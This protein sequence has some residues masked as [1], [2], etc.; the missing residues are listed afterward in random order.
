MTPTTSSDAK[1]VKTRESIRSMPNESPISSS[2]KCD[3]RRTYESPIGNSAKKPIT[4][5][6]LRRGTTQGRVGICRKLSTDNINQYSNTNKSSLCVSDRIASV[7]STIEAYD[8]PKAYLFYRMFQGVE[9]IETT[10]TDGIFQAFSPYSSMDF[11]KHF[12]SESN[13]TNEQL[14]Y[15]L[16]GYG[17]NEKFQNFQTNSNVQNKVSDCIYSLT[18]CKLFFMGRSVCI[19]QE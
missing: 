18:L 14:D 17:I 13:D 15:H 9:E 5:T 3:S 10:T 19:L 6:F 16:H 11:Q 4:S 2:P 7:V 8:D 1:Q 12:S